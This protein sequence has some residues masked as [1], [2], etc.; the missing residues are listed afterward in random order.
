MQPDEQRTRR[1]RYF[2]APQRRYPSPQAP[3]LPQSPAGAYRSPDGAFARLSGESAALVKER[4]APASP[5][6][7][8][9]FA[10]GVSKH[11]LSTHCLLSCR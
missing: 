2:H 11:P 3:R 6:V 7:R 5:P 1:A 10:V 9:P 4:R 8:E